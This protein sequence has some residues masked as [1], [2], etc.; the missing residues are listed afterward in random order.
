MNRSKAVLASLM[1]L[2]PALFGIETSFAEEKQM[3]QDEMVQR[4]RLFMNCQPVNLLVEGL[5]KSTSRIGLT[6]RN[7]I[8]AAE[9]RLRSAR[10]YTDDK[11]SPKLYINVQVRES[12][13]SLTIKLSKRLHD[14]ISGLSTHATSWESSGLG[15]HSR[16]GRETI[17]SRVAM[18]VDEFIVQYQRVNEKAC[19]QK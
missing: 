12:V 7:I 19:E 16:G 4:F 11:L 10:I 8:A 6:E 18:E 2:V 1:L 14:P 5:D 13:Y 17:M 15:T 9:S 3:S